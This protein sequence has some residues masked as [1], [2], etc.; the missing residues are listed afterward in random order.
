MGNA[1]P[2]SLLGSGVACRER[3]ETDGELAS[4]HS[5]LVLFVTGLNIVLIEDSWEVVFG[6][7]VEFTVK[8]VF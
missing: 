3:A 2:V 5:M 8:V 4:L 1:R 6:N 7:I